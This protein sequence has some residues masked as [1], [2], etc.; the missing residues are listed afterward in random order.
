MT[1]LKTLKAITVAITAIT[2]TST[3]ATAAAIIAI[4]EDAGNTTFSISGDFDTSGLAQFSGPNSTGLGTSANYTNTGIFADSND[5]LF[6]GGGSGGGANPTTDLFIGLDFSSTGGWTNSSD[7][8]TGSATVV[9]SP[10]STNVLFFNDVSNAA[11]ISGGSW[12][13]TLNDTIANLGF[14]ENSTGVFTNPNNSDTLTIAVT[15]VPEPSG[16]LLSGMGGLAL[17]LRRRRA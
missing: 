6:F 3:N 7:A 12:S 9:V 17:L 8:Y 13:F 4:V 11:G 14:T 15:S 16:L 5:V 2:L 10:N 1:K